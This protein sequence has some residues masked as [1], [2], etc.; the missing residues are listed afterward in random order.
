MRHKHMPL[1]GVTIFDLT[2]WNSIG[3]RFPRHQVNRQ[4]SSV[5]S[6]AALRLHQ[7]FFPEPEAG[8]VQ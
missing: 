5:I 2:P 3:G 4:F 1:Q 6:T 7:L 8:A